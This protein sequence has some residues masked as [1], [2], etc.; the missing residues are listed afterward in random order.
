MSKPKAAHIIVIK[1]W[2]VKTATHKN[3]AQ[4]SA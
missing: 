2:N 3:V 4:K 1:K